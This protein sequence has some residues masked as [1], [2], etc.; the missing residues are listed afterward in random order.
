MGTTTTTQL[1]TFEEFELLPDTLGK[2]ELLEGELIELPIPEF[3]HSANFHRI[4]RLVNL[5][6]QWVL[7]CFPQFIR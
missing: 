6:W 4:F 3:S 5:A 1:L 2:R 7:S